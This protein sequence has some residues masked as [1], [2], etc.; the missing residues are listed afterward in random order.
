MAVYLFTKNTVLLHEVQSHLTNHVIRVSREST[1][2]KVCSTIIRDPHAILIIDESYHTQGLFP[3]LEY[4]LSCNLPGPRILIPARK[5]LQSSYASDG[6][7]AILYRPFTGRQFSRCLLSLL[8]LSVVR[9]YVKED[10]IEVPELYSREGTDNLIGTSAGIREIRDMIHTIA[11]R[12]RAVHITGETGTGKEVV[13]DTIISQSPESSVIEKVNC[14]T[15]PV[16][17]ADSFLFGARK[18][19]YTDSKEDRPGCIERA[20][21]GILF[22]DEIEDL[23][24]EIQGKLLRVIESGEFLPVGSD[25]LLHSRFQLISASNIDIEGLIRHRSFRL[26]LYHRITPIIIRIPPLR[27][28]IEDI[29]LLVDHFLHRE[30]EKRQVTEDSLERLMEYTWPGNIRQLYNVLEQLR[31]FTPPS[32]PLSLDALP[33]SQIFR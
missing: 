19:A 14:S 31:L 4:I 33:T 22:L 5:G 24:Y 1:I 9:E 11:D 18:G 3:L 26:D 23:P 8:P 21:G 2:R 6:T 20:H 17:L 25:H 13:A 10:L 32:S 30:H 29:P 12:Y 7:T 16:S 28:R 15:I 27:E